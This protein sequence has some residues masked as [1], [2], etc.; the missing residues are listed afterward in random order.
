MRLMKAVND[1]EEFNYEKH[2]FSF[3]RKKCLSYNF[4]ILQ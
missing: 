4:D 3:V 2:D 1:K